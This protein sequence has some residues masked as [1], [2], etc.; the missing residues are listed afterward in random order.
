MKEINI[1]KWGKDNWLSIVKKLKSNGIYELE[2]Y[3]VGKI[4]KTL[5]LKLISNNPDIQYENG[6]NVDEINEDNF[7]N[8]TRGDFYSLS[9]KDAIEIMD[10]YKIW[11][12]KKNKPEF[13]ETEYLGKLKVKFESEN[14]NAYFESRSLSYYFVGDGFIIRISDHWSESKYPKSK[15]LNC[16]NIGTCFCSR[17]FL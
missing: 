5:E 7:H 2:L 12:R 4:I 8:A 1:D 6:G 17:Y 13:I 9:V 15:K 11:R 3:K 10:K 14:K 16:G